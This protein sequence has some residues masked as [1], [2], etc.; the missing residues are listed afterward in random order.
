MATRLQHNVITQFFIHEPFWYFASLDCFVLTWFRA[1]WF[2]PLQLS[3]LLHQWLHGSEEQKLKVCTCS[4]SF[5]LFFH[6]LY[7]FA[8]AHMYFSTNFD[9]IHTFFLPFTPLS[10][11]HLSE[12]I[13][14]LLLDFCMSFPWSHWRAGIESH[15]GS[16]HLEMC[17]AQTTWIIIELYCN[18]LNG[19]R[20]NQYCYFC[21]EYRKCE[22]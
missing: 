9:V 15:Y 1:R 13:Y 20:L 16:N 2:E 22:N 21:S 14:S 7:L 19:T 4:C 11:T 6:L 5:V 18:N 12:S 8:F 10:H 17:V 3:L